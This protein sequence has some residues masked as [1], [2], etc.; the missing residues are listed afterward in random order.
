MSLA[1]ASAA[2]PQFDIGNMAVGAKSDLMAGS[3]SVL[4]METG[5][6]RSGGKTNGGMAGGGREKGF[7]LQVDG[8]RGRVMNGSG[9]IM[10]S[11]SRIAQ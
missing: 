7:R 10:T 11:F 8:E 4:G 1:Q 2:G 6:M 9:E 5:G 3:S